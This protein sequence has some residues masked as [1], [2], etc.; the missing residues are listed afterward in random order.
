MVALAARVVKVGFTYIVKPAVPDQPDKEMT[1]SEVTEKFRQVTVYAKT[2]SGQQRRRIS[3]IQCLL[4]DS[5]AFLRVFEGLTYSPPGV[6]VHPLLY[7]LYKPFDV[8]GWHVSVPP[9]ELQ[10]ALLL[11]WDVVANLYGDRIDH[12]RFG[13]LHLAK[14]FQRPDLRLGI[15]HILWS[16]QGTGKSTFLNFLEF[17]F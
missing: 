2:G 7:N 11:F 14:I 12:M 1:A 4:R 10:H 9:A 6:P 16:E 8:Y 3:V 17:F 13:I 5:G 15:L